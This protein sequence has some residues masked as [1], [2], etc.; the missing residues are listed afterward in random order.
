MNE[1]VEIQIKLATDQFTKGM[2]GV[3]N[4][5]KTTNLALANMV[6]NLATSAFTNFARGA[7]DAFGAVFDGAKNLESTR[8][9]FAT[10]TGSMED[11]E[12][13]VNDLRKAAAST[14]FEMPGLQKATTQ[15]LTLE[16]VT[17]DNVI[18]T[19]MKLGDV[20]AVGAGDIEGLTAVFVKIQS[21]GKVTAETLESL[22]NQSPIMAQ[23]MVEAAGVSGM[24]ALR[25]AMA[26]GAVGADVLEKAIANVTSQ[27]GKAFDAMAG[28]AGT[29]EGQ[30]SNLADNFTNLAG[31]I[32]T[33]LLPIFKSV[34]SEIIGIVEANK[35][36][37]VN[38]ATS[39]FQAFS[40]VLTSSL[41]VLKET[42]RLYKENAEAIEAM[43]DAAADMVTD[44]IDFFDILVTRTVAFVAKA[45]D[46][47]NNW[48]NSAK[49]SAL[50]VKA[51]MLEATNV[52]GIWDEQIAA[53]KEA[54]KAIQVEMDAVNA[55]IK[56]VN[57]AAE[58]EIAKILEVTEV[59]KEAVAADIA[60]Q[61]AKIDQEKI[62][63]E[64][65][66]AN[67]AELNAALLEQ[68]AIFREEKALRDQAQAELD[69]ANA[70]GKLQFLLDNLGAEDSMKRLAEI[71]DLKARGK[72]AEALGK[73]DEARKAAVEKRNQ[74]LLKEQAET[75]KKSKELAERHEKEKLESFISHEEAKK[76]FQEMTE[77]EKV[78]TLDDGLKAMTY[79]MRSGNK[80]MFRIGQ[81]AA[82]AQTTMDTYQMAVKSYNALAGIPI[83]GPGLAAAAAA[84]AITYGLARVQSIR[85]QKFAHGG[86]VAGNNFAGDQVTA[87]VNSGEMVLNKSQQANLF[88]M[89]NSGGSNSGVI[90][91]IQGLGDRIANLEIV[92]VADDNEIARSTSRG[93][94]SGIV[95]GESR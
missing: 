38:M 35:T 46:E 29:L 50:Q 82:I 2:K 44:T 58:A 57:E 71:N 54:T 83:V 91:A 12:K 73:L 15:L 31:D 70:A 64:T 93:V 6:G 14:P 49:L 47:F 56:A 7:A 8:K 95:I 60:T 5:L 23:A 1:N 88:N 33:N 17:S 51:A 79:L 48:V 84:G 90:S 62:L 81:A 21:Q 78:Q 32:G 75:A 65:K 39:A 11:A 80:E 85:S 63:A 67:E 74:E 18:P 55:R 24:G 3:Q 40:V 13:V 16:G 19:L 61:T 36:L 27:G 92:L 45:G 52:G 37:I 28:Q 87:Q 30:M 26:K 9:I 59:K 10:L 43:G 72:H 86:I 94:Q 4:S 34:V 42:I 20:A 69:Q 77:K 25:E 41:G 89:A 76:K 22:T 53:T 66:K 68:D